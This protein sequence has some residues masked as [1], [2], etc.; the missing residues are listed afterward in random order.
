MDTQTHLNGIDAKG[1]MRLAAAIATVFGITKGFG[2]S[3]LL[4]LTNKQK[5]TKEVIQE[6]HIYI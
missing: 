4:N 1:L 6:L 2:E 5:P 3:R